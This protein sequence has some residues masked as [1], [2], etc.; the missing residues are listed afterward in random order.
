MG[1]TTPNAYFDVELSTLPFAAPNVFDLSPMNKYR[2]TG[3][4]AEAYHVNMVTRDV[5]QI[6]KSRWICRLVQ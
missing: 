6:G 1:Y 2:I 3:P 4:D 5:S